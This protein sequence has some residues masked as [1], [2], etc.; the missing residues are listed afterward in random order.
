MLDCGSYCNFISTK[1][2]NKLNLKIYNLKTTINVKGIS[3]ITTSIKKY[4][5]LNF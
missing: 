1:L 3:G 5:K 4:V 2:V